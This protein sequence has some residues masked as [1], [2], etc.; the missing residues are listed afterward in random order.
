MEV[1]IPKVILL[2]DISL[3]GATWEAVCHRPKKPK[4]QKVEI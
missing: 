1:S 2:D 4:Q 3:I